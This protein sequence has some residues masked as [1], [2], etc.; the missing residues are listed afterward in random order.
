M[1]NKVILVGN[2]GAD[3][4][5]RY[6]TSGTAVAT[7]SVA[8]ERRWKD[9]EGNT[10]TETEWHRVIAWDFRAEFAGNYLTKGKKVYVEGRMQTRKWQ[11]QQGVDRYTTE[12]I[13]SDL[14]NLS[15]RDADSSGPPRESYPPPGG[16]QQSDSLPGQQGMFGAGTGDDVPF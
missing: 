13:C 6:T 10:Q 8:T 3:P 14:Q 7:L 9:K 1:V 12:V 11:D 2:L 15:P 16:Q 5:L 4:D